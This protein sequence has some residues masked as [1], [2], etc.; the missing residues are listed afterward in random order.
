M[1]FLSAMFIVVLAVIAGMLAYDAAE[2]FQIYYVN[3]EL[4]Y[5]TIGALALLG[6]LVAGAM[7]V[8]EITENY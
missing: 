8:T 7:V 4:R 5:R 3:G 2:A 1:R 6:A